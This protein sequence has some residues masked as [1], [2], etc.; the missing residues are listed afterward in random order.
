MSETT[1]PAANR[2]FPTEDLLSVT[3]GLLF[4]TWD[5]LYALI[6]FVTGVSHM[7]HQLP[8]ASDVV[9][10]WLLEQHPWLANI[11]VPAGVEAD[12]VFEPWFAKLVAKH[13][14]THAVTAMPPGKY[15]GRDPLVE[16]REMAP[17]TPIIAIVPAAD[18][19]AR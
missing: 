10:P 3:T 2:E 16:L 12:E 15:E 13:G 14:K 8:R 18:G 17:N 9:K 1:T 5:G 6:D 4:G 7:T 11:A 19:G